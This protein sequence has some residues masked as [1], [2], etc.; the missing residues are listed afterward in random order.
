MK[1]FLFVMMLVLLATADCCAVILLDDSTQADGARIT[2]RSNIPGVTVFSDSAY[3]GTTPIDSV[4]LKAGTH[5]LKFLHPETRNWLHPAIIETVL[6]APLEHLYRTIEFPV[7]YYITSDPYGATVRSGDSLLGQTPLIVSSQSAKNV[8]TIAKDGFE[9]IS[10][11][12]NTDQQ[13]VHVMLVRL[14]GT[15]L[16]Q[17]S[18]YLSSEQSNSSLNIYVTTG[19]T[20]I[21]GLAAAYFK[22]K[23]D[24]YYSDYQRTNDPSLLNKVR[25]YDTI[26]GISL[27]VSEISLF[28][29]S[30]LLLSR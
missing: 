8:I 4:Q 10:I 20:V 19:T 2:I 27:S 9:D 28:V 3:L 12:L 22:I 30:Y 26:A 13:S 21:T 7:L 25:T 14:N 11:P 18:Q 29:L 6:L 1:I 17:R 16:D 23:A 5:I 15:M 24:S